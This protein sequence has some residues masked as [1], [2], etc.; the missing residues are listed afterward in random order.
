[1]SVWKVA[2]VSTLILVVALEPA[3]AQDQLRTSRHI[4]ATGLP[5]TGEDADLD[6]D[7]VPPANIDY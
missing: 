5:K 2:F 7:E 3:C 1:M 4:V 6:I